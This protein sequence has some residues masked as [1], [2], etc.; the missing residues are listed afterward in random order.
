MTVPRKRDRRAGRSRGL[1]RSP[2]RT[3]GGYGQRTEQELGRWRNRTRGRRGRPCRAARRVWPS[4]RSPI[5]SRRTHRSA[6]RCSRGRRSRAGC[7]SSRRRRPLLGAASGAVFGFTLEALVAAFFCWI[8]VIVTRTDLE[9][10]LIPNRIVLP[11]AVLVLVGRTARRAE[12]R[13]A[14]RRPRR[15]LGLF[16]LALVYPRGM[17][18]GDVKLALFMGSGL[19]ACGGRSAL[20]LGFLAARVPAHRAARAAREGGTQA[21][22]PLG[23]FLALGAVVALF[24]GDAIL[25]WYWDIGRSM[26]SGRTRCS[27]RAPR[28]PIPFSWN[29]RPRPA[30]RAASTSTPRCSLPRR[31][32]RRRRRAEDADAARAIDAAV[33]ALHDAVAGLFPSVFVLE[34]GRLWLVAQRGYAVVPT[35]S[36]SSRGSWAARFALGHDQLSP[37]VHADPDYL[38]ALPASISELAIPLR[39]GGVV[40][41]ALNV[42]S[43]RPLPEDAAELI[44]PL[45]AALAPL[46]EELRGAARSTSRLS[47]G[48]SSTSGA[49]ATPTRSPRSPPRRSPAS[50]RSRRA[51]SWSGTTSGAPVELASWSVGGRVPALLS[52]SRARRHRA[53]SSIRPWSASCSTAGRRVGRLVVVWLPLRANGNELGALVRLRPRRAASDAEQLDIAPFSPPTSAAS[54]DAAVA[55]DRER[56]SAVTDS[57]TGI[58][59]RRGLEERLERELGS[60]RSGAA[61]EPPRPRLRR[62]QGRQR[63]RGARVRRRAAARDRAGARSARCQRAPRRRGSAATSSSSCSP[64]PARTPAPSSAAQLRARLAEG[65]DGRRLPAAAERGDLDLPVR[66]RDGDGAPPCRATRRSTPPRTRAR[67]GS[68]R[69]RTSRAPMPNPV[70]RRAVAVDGGGGGRAATARSWPTSCPPRW[71][72]TRRTTVDGVCSRLCKWLVFV[73]G[74]TGCS[75]SRVVGDYLVDATEHAFARSR[76]AT[77]PP[78]ASPTSRSP[79]RR[80]DRRAAGVSFLDGDVDPAEAFIL[81]EL[82]MNACSS[83]AARRRRAV[84]SRRAVRD[85]APAV[86]GGRRRRRAVPRRPGRAS[87]RRLWAPTPR[88]RRRPSTSCRRTTTRRATAHEVG[89]RAGGRRAAAT[90]PIRG[91]RRTPRRRSRALARRK[92]R[93]RSR[94]ACSRSPG[95]NASSSRRTPPREPARR[96]SAGGRLLSRSSSASSR[97]AHEPVP[98]ARPRRASARPRRARFAGA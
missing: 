97:S 48:S 28:T 47:P 9:H 49:F 84:G 80:S 94:R 45:A 13:L 53:R 22:D 58:L 82:G 38:G 34:H 12:R 75:A 85:A 14:P 25:D 72:S 39:A 46:A 52:V 69:S 29:G 8:L 67:T 60:R 43:E 24:V 66:R 70:D 90:G 62:L 74:A 93:A 64:A 92:C 5:G 2:H 68:R 56:R 96:A 54:L 86:H 15:V 51:R 77:R 81:R 98:A 78:I 35:A 95:T 19:G 20:F 11:G 65:L 73:V 50:S 4:A 23:P 42:E 63:S 88:R 71:R 55:L 31:A 32:G 37:H 59:N 6:R 89:A 33:G 27:R 57:L 91:R 18:M 79:P 44:R 21:G 87:A 17:G 40:V 3:E 1:R 30:R 26:R 10:R 76:W 61:A 7:R 36:A 16:L 83:S 41:G